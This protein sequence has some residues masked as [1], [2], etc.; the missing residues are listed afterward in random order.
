ML[1]E[2]LA[3]TWLAGFKCWIF[4]FVFSQSSAFFFFFFLW[5]E[6]TMPFAQSSDLLFST[7]MGS[8]M[9]FDSY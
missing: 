7:I 6:L 8:E 9:L 5:I 4:C 2:I 3:G 1:T